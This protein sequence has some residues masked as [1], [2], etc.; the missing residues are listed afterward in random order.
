MSSLPESDAPVI[1]VLP[2]TLFFQIHT[3]ESIQI[4]LNALKLAHLPRLF[5]IASL[6]LLQ[7]SFIIDASDQF[8]LSFVKGAF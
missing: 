7:Q 6:F 4:T 1:L 5:R 2:E 3:P 8:S